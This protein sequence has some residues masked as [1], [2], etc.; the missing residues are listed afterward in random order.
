[1]RL[2]TAAQTKDVPYRPRR[3]ALNWVDYLVIAAT[4]LVF[5]VVV[6]TTGDQRAR[7]NTNSALV[8]NLPEQA[9]KVPDELIKAR[10]RLAVGQ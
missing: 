9:V 8:P 7:A 3:S 4:A 10:I 1:M 5:L 6:A 2:S